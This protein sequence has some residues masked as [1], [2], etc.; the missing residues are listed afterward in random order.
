MTPLLCLV[1]PTA[2][3]KSQ[4]ALLVAP[5]LNAEIVSA[6][7][8]QIY[9][10]MDI[11][12][13]KP[14][15]EER[16]RVPHHLID[17]IEA[18]RP[19]SVAEYQAEAERVIAETHTR[20]HLAM[21]VGGSGL[22]VRAVVDG[23]DFP[24]A[25]PDWQLREALAAEADRIGLEQLHQRLAE[26]DPAA[27]QRIQPRDQKR[28]IRALE[29][30]YQTGRPITEFHQL[31]Q[32]RAPRYNALILGLTMPRPQLYRRIEERVD[33]MMAQGLL[34]EVAGLLARGYHEGL[35]SMKALGYQHLALHLRGEYDLPT[36]V[37]L[38]KRDTRR[39]AKRQL[40]WFGRDPRVQ[41]IEV[42]ED[43]MEQ[44]AAQVI[45]RAGDHFGLDK[46]H[47]V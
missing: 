9:R 19:Y 40:T 18:D 44:A 5:A 14:T 12:T 4:V 11:G 25:G 36:A 37:E 17:L 41:W 27:A 3:G 33:R 23:L 38:F 34:E 13:A 32:A 35:T 20:G 16:A 28:I 47:R 21:L 1:G 39:F 7:S 42:Q 31:D 22:Y 43:R 45:E 26:V 10:G 24:I 15:P 30:F 2:A 8:M 6:D 29:V 46:E